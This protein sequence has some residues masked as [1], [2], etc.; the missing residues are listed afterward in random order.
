MVAKGRIPKNEPGAGGAPSGMGTLRIVSRGLG[1]LLEIGVL[2]RPVDTTLHPALD[3][4]DT[5][6]D[7]PAKRARKARKRSVRQVSDEKLFDQFRRGDLAA[8]RVLI[9]RYKDDLL[10]F[11][12]RLVGDRAA[13]E[14][15]FQETFLQIYQS[16]DTFDIERR[17]RPWLFTIAANKGRDYLRKKIRRRELDLDAPVGGRGGGGGEASATTFV[18]LLEIEVDPPEARLSAGE[19]EELVQRALA[20]L[21][22]ALKEIL[23]LAYFQRLSYVQIADELGIPLGTV[24]SRLHAAVAAFA[25]R[26][27][28]V[29][30][31]AA[32]NADEPDEQPV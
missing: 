27:Q 31:R 20:G 14:D 26:W 1:R 8:L 17:F 24:K 28:Q 32:G 4:W 5:A 13:A 7:R 25:K 6:S 30:R 16:S 10:R 9:E 3:P 2:D 19:R 11:L 29:S 23:L 21:S 15:V 22:P 12:F 18:D